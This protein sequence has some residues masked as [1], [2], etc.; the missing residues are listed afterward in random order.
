VQWLIWVLPERGNPLRV[1]VEEEYI[2]YEKDIPKLKFYLEYLDSI[3]KVKFEEYDAK[4]M[5]ELL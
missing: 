5:E 3:L 2:W 4:H 1:H